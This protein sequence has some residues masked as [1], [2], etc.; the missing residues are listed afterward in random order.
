MTNEFQC[1]TQRE[2]DMCIRALCAQLARFHPD[3]QLHP[4]KKIDIK[5]PYWP[6]GRLN[7]VIGIAFHAFYHPSLPSDDG[8]VIEPGVFCA[9]RPLFDRPA[10]CAD[11]GPEQAVFP[12]DLFPGPKPKKEHK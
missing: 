3:N 6:P 12:L 9:Y 1:L 10:R 5:S 4:G 8:S 2:L 11:C 7:K